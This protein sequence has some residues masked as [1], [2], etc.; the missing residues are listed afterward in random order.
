MRKRNDFE[1]QYDG[2]ATNFSN[3]LSKYNDFESFLKLLKPKSK[4]LDLGCGAG[5]YTN[6]L[7][8]AGMDVLGIDISRD[9]VAEAKKNYPGLD[10]I[11]DNFFRYDFSKDQFDAVWCA[12]VFLH[13]PY[14]LN[15]LF[16]LKVRKILK[17]GGFFYLVTRVEEQ[18]KDG[19]V[20]IE[21]NVKNG[22]AESKT[23][24]KIIS[25]ANLEKLLE[26]KDFEIRTKKYCEKEQTEHL[27]CMNGKKKDELYSFN[28]TSFVCGNCKKAFGTILSNEYPQ[29][30]YS[31][32]VEKLSKLYGGNILDA[33]NDGVLCKKCS[34]EIAWENLKKF[35]KSPKSEKGSSAV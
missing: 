33:N 26:G 18:E 27:I 14:S 9:M 17:P 22:P 31:A 29:E 12:D 32:V 13:I 20:G 25:P 3:G 21:W 30:E 10:F 23:Y 15:N 35:S 6:A 24:W 4:V 1:K 2:V 7:A 11:L 16:M 8:A 34:L 28:G 5:R 19:W